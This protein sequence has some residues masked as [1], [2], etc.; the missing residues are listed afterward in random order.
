MRTSADTYLSQVNRSN[1]VR[2]RF[3]RTQRIL[4]FLV[5]ICVFW[6]LKLTGITMAGD[7]FCGI[8]EHTHG[9]NCVLQKQVCTQEE[10]PAH[11]HEEACL[12]R[13]L[14]CTL[15]EQPGHSHSNACIQKE[16]V[17]T[18]EETE[19]HIHTDTCYIK[20]EICSLPEEAPHVHGDDCYTCSYLCGM[21]ESGEHTHDETCMSFTLTC[22]L[23]ESPGHSHGEAC[24]RLDLA[25][26]L[27]EAEG[28]MHDASCYTVQ[29]GYICGEEETSGH[30]HT[31][32]CYITEDSSY[33]CGLEETEGHCHTESCFLILESCPLEEHIH[34][35]SCYSDLSADLETRDDWELSLSELV[36]SSISRENLVMV[37]KSQL[38]ISESFRNFQVDEYGIR[39]GITRYGQWYGNPYGDWSAMFVSFCL[40]YAGIQDAPTNAGPETM[41][42]AWEESMVYLTP[43]EAEPAAGDLLF[44]DKDE[45]GAADAVA[46][47][48][49]IKENVLFV[50]EGDL[51]EPVTQIGDI[52]LNDEKETESGETLPEETVYLSEDTP[53]EPTSEGEPVF[54]TPSTEEPLQDKVAETLYA[55]EDPVILGYGMIPL[56]SDY[57]PL[58]V[59]DRCAVWLDGTNGGMM[60]LSGSSNQRIDAIEGST[61]KL[62]ET[63]SSP[64]KYSYSLRGWYDVTNSQ[65]YAPGAEVKV[66]GNMVFYADWAAST[67]DVGQFNAQVVD[68]VSTNDFVTVRMFDYGVLFNVLSEWANV[69]FSNNGHTET[70]NLLTSG[71]NPYNGQQTLNYIFRDWD[72]GNEDISYPNGTNAPNNPTDAGQVYPGL[73]TDTIRNLLFEPD[74]QV[75]GKQYLGE[76]D[77]LFQLCL[78]PNHEHY[79]YYYYNSERNAAS[80]NQSD[81]RFY[82]Y[83]YLECTRTSF[84]NSENTD[85]GKYSDFLPLNSPYA[86][87]NGKQVNTYAYRGIEGEYNGTTHYMYDCRYNDSNNSPNYAGTNFFFGMSV[88]IDFYLPNAPG[89]TVPGGGYGNQ[90]IY[91]KDMHFQFSGDDDV[92]V[93][94]DGAMV[95]DLGG[96]HGMETGDINFATGVVTINGVVNQTL[97]N[98]L[99]SISSGEHTLS[100]YYLERGSSMS[101]CAI[102]FNLAPRFNFSIQKEDILTRDVLNGAQFSVY[103]DQACTVP[104]QLWTSK[105]AHD[106]G[107]APTNVFTVTNGTANMWGM[108]AGNTYYIKETKPPDDPDY[109][110]IPN[111]VIR[112]SF[113]KLGT[114]SYDVE[115][116]DTGQGIS[117]GFTV[118]G[119]RVD[120]ETQQ[121]YIVATNAP[122]WV[123]E[124]TSVQVWKQWQDAKNHIADH[125]TVYLTVTHPNG[126]VQ[127]LQEAQLSDTNDWYYRWDN[128]PK[129]WEDGT[130]PVRYGVEEAYIPGYYSKTE[131]IT[132]YSAW[133][134]QGNFENG[135]TYLLKTANGYLSTQNTN[136]DTGFMWV[137]Q[138]TAENSSLA[139]WKAAVSDNGV[140][141]TNEAGQSLTFYYNGGSSGYPT[142]FFASSGGEND[143]S[144]QFFRYSSTSDGLRIYY[145]GADGRDYYLRPS[146]TGAQKFE[147]STSASDAL[148]FTPMACKEIL[149][150]EGIGYLITNAPLTQET[151]L[152][153]EKHWDYGKLNSGTLHEQAQVTVRLLANGKDTGRS[154][155]LSLRNNWKNTFQGLPYVDDTGNVIAYSVEESWNTLD[156]VPEYGEVV[157]LDGNPPTY[158]TTVTN[159]YIWGYS[160]PQLPS[161]GTAARM[162]YILC[163]GSIMLA[164]LG[165]GIVLRRKRERRT[166]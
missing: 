74:T 138:E 57:A 105:E 48:T 56:A 112:L 76:G 89:S 52:S 21:E 3:H 55:L 32:T 140:R 31:D 69:S 49:G 104:A 155:T 17:C 135:Q 19:G 35:E 84:A 153:V 113:D 126:T 122:L 123:N 147:Y 100:L 165:Y 4:S 58:A 36:R 70:W 68:T 163:G 109:A 134:P 145:D 120:A 150:T 159:R 110:G 130:T 59:G 99:K 97:S 133:Y 114:A 26:S 16:Q 7:A 106:Q 142:D 10:I 40:D 72:Q 85:S 28:H 15:P 6:G 67:Y 90:D 149:V 87:T 30:V 157:T 24:F 43:E 132:V 20:K 41:R 93:F 102:Y 63:W 94:V 13:T 164:S 18:L 1:S 115:I 143:A 118:H 137:Q 44:L 151:S 9:E 117:G 121:A 5:I 62:P 29:P 131:E 139:R 80:Y 54:E 39:H 166:K 101:N 42:L 60:S 8:G 65:Y 96:L 81:Q 161:T 125:I 27:E 156:W 45:N 14:Q 77:H 2:S 83:N 12:S 98:N 34:T 129:F 33:I 111:G 61:I 108:G 127:R 73:Y 22:G 66:T 88:D 92:W 158:S 141:L 25:C 136:S 47:V 75:I 107:V 46:V 95:L 152:T 144:K 124:T 154:V 103:T 128:L 79:G 160:I 51:A 53:D 146:M 78:D 148:L 162:L 37:A 50:I 71:S 116:I 23:A 86:N 82:V 11:V 119:L 38:G 64:A 91:G